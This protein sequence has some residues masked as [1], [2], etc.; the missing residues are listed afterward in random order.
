MRGCIKFSDGDVLWFTDDNYR[1]IINGLT[2]NQRD[3][4]ATLLRSRLGPRNPLPVDVDPET[5]EVWHEDTH[6]KDVILG[7]GSSN[8]DGNKINKKGGKKY[9]LKD[10]HDKG[11]GDQNICWL[12]NIGFKKRWSKKVGYRYLKGIVEVDVNLIG[13]LDHEDFKVKVSMLLEG[14]DQG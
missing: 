6:R 9:S 1:N 8:S 4:L 10:W 12:L 3:Q 14:I 11:D 13:M 5:Y 7:G 2:D